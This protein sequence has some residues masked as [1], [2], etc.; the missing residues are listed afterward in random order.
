MFAHSNRGVWQVTM[1]RPSKKMSAK[2]LLTFIGALTLAGCESTSSLL[3]VTPVATEPDIV[4]VKLAM[5]ADK[6]AKALDVIASIDQARSNV[7][8]PVEDYSNVPPNLMQPVSLRWSGPAEQVIKALADRA[9]LRFRTKGNKPATPLI[10][11]V[12]AYQQPIM[13]VLTNI[14][15]QLGRRADVAVDSRGGAIELRYARR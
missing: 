11:N 8:P 3:S 15:L 6:A 4:T 13:H 14:G 7:T 10:V 2:I 5:A 12:D 1:K 9:G